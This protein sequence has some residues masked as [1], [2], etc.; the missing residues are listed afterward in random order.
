MLEEFE[1][2]LS[3][4]FENISDGYLDRVQKFFLKESKK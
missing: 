4:L 1:K 3:P 2:Y